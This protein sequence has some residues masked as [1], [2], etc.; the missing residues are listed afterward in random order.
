MRRR[1]L[2][3]FG[4][5][6]VRFGIICTDTLDDFDKPPLSASYTA[7]SH[8]HGLYQWNANADWPIAGELKAQCAK[9]SSN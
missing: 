3:L 5:S 9:F 6:L 1:V 4:N 7:L 8:Q 2:D